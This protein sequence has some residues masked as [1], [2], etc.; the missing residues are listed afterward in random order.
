MSIFDYLA[1]WILGEPLENCD[2]VCKKN[3][4]MCS[5][6]QFALHND[7]VNT[8]GKVLELIKKLGGE[9]SAK[10]CKKGAFAAVPAFNKDSFCMYSD[11]PSKFDCGKV[12]GPSKAN[13]QRLCYCHNP[14]GTPI[15]H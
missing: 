14:A 7:D 2:S 5:E 3:H 10:S 1:G 9:T 13:K 15:I 8:S 4:M 12:A 11:S 6:K